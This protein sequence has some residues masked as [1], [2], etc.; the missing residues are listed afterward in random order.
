[1]PSSLVYDVDV[2]VPAAQMYGYFTTVGYWEDLVEHYRSHSSQTEIAHFSSDETGTDITFAHI[3]SAQD[4]PP[5]ARRV[6]SGSFI[7]KREQHFDPFDTPANQ[8]VGR[9]RADVPVPLD[10]TGDYVL[11]DT[12]RGSRMRLTTS[13]RMRVPIIGGQIEQLV[14]GGLKSMFAGEGEF[15]AEWVAAHR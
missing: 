3:M 13:C 2:D 9:Y 12:E 4:L 15:T 14:L 1:M 5:V 7:V 10:L 6:I 11:H 8:A